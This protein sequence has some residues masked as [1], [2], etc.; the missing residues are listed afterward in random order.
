MSE[1]GGDGTEEVSD[2]L[3]ETAQRAVSAHET[4]AMIGRTRDQP[5]P[6]PLDETTLPPE[7]QR[8]TSI[9]WSGPGVEAAAQIVREIGYEMTISGNPPAVTPMVQD[10]KRVV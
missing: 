2:L 6:S 9:D 10:R 1:L 7:L 3:A 4:R 5:A 8:A